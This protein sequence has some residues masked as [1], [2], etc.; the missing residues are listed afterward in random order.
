MAATVRTKY[1]ETQVVGFP[2]FTPLR[3]LNQFAEN[4][5]Q[6]PY[7]LRNCE[8][9]LP[10]EGAC[11]RRRSK[12]VHSVFA[13]FPP[14]LHETH[15]APL[16]E[17]ITPWEL[18]FGGETRFKKL[19]KLQFAALHVWPRGAGGVESGGMAFT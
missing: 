1:H 17:A 16:V 3:I 7:L 5:R 9:T 19:F 6:R 8:H 11:P 2:L 10:P 13:A 12:G 15:S 14:K 4:L 18:P